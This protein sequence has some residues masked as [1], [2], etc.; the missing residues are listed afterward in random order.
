M[1]CLFPDFMNI[2]HDVLSYPLNEETDKQTQ[3]K[4]LRPR[5]PVV[6]EVTID[7]LYFTRIVHPV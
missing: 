4:I 2:T 6:A 3:V 1:T 5:Q 7:N